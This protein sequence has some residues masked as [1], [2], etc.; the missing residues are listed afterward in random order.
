MTG[1]RSG[2]TTCP[3]QCC[4]VLQLSGT[5]DELREAAPI[6]L[7]GPSVLA[8][9]EPIRR[10]DAIKRSLQ[11]GADPTAISQATPGR[12]FTCR[13]WDTETHLCRVYEQRPTMCRDYPYG[14]ACA[15]C[16]LTM[17]VSPLDRAQQRARREGEGRMRAHDPAGAA[18]GLPAKKTPRMRGQA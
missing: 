5:L 11:H 18:W 8:M 1:F 17:G 16:G 14:E 3:G 2:A 10:D 13:H 15:H 12:L 9:I 7:D 4:A 6:M